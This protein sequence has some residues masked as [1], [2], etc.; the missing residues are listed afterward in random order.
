M[1]CEPQPQETA[2]PTQLPRF[3]VYAFPTAVALIGVGW[4]LRGRRADA[5]RGLGVRARVLVAAAIFGAAASLLAVVATL[6]LRPAIVLGKAHAFNSVLLPE[7]RA[8]R[9]EDTTAALEHWRFVERLRTACD[10]LDL[11][12]SWSTFSVGRE[13]AVR[14]DGK[15]HVVFSVP[16][17][18]VREFS[19]RDLQVRYIATGDSPL[20]R[21]VMQRNDRAV[22][23]VVET[24]RN[25]ESLTRPAEGPRPLP[26]GVEVYTEWPFDTA[27][28]RRRQQETAAALGLP[29]EEVV[30]LGGGQTLTL[31]LVPAGEFR[32]GCVLT[33][34]EID[35]R[36][37]DAQGKWQKGQIALR[38]ARV[39]RPMYVGRTEVTRGQFAE[40]VRQ[41]GFTT[42]AEDFGRASTVRKVDGE[43]TI[44]WR[45]GV[46]WRHPGFAQTDAHPAV[47]VTRSDAVIFCKWLSWKGRRTY[48]LP[49]GVQWE[50]A[51]R[52]GSDG[53][54]PW[55][56]REEDTQGQANVACVGEDLD[57]SYA[58]KP[59]VRDGHTY[60]APVASFAPNAFG[61]YDT[62]GNVF[63]RYAEWEPA[64]PEDEAMRLEELPVWR[65]RG[66]GWC[67]G[68]LD[69]RASYRSDPLNYPQTSIGFRVCRDAWL[70]AVTEAALPSS[71]ER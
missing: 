15:V 45:E 34:E 11:S 65:V 8:D 3:L 5:G 57:W 35:R 9:I 66:G 55:G 17:W 29:I 4:V 22:Q 6:C 26:E 59:S 53:V 62:I 32:M 21:D 47:C 24:I 28:A 71:V 14:P 39:D 69:S 50:Y 20:A 37:P 54:W 70:P 52:A 61:L 19:W 25:M 33:P 67:S 63:E 41:T 56:S 42:E 43:W 1:Y 13:G 16:A 7:A 49:A 64:Q 36:W 12:A 27:E 68:P 51:C 2:P 38:R 44:P 46:D 58:Y 18:C 23:S 40:F 10:D 30:D 31:V 60:T 48:T